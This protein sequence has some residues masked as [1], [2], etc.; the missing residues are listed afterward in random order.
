MA[1]L[2]V[3]AAQFSQ[4]F[5]IPPGNVTPIW[6]PSGIIIA[7]IIIRGNHVW[8]GIFLGAFFG[9]VWAYFDFQQFSNVSASLFAGSLNGLGNAG[10]GLLTIYLLKRF[11]R[12][13]DI[14]RRGKNVILFVFIGAVLPSF[15]SAL[16]G[17]SSLAISKILPWNNFIT[18]F[19]TWF[20]G[21]TAGIILVTPLIL[22]AKN[23]LSWKWL[24]KVKRIELVI[25]FTATILM[26]AV[27]IILSEA[28]THFSIPIISIL[29]LV[30]WGAYRLPIHINHFL[31]L[32]LSSGIFGLTLSGGGPFAHTEL[33][34]AL[35]EMQYFLLAFITAIL[36]IEAN[37]IDRLD[38]KAELETSEK[39]NRV[40]I[41]EFPIGLALCDMEGILVDINQPFADILGRSI[42]ESKSLTYWE[43]TPESYAKEEEVQ[44]NSLS[45]LGHYGPYEKDYIH[46]DSHLV[47]VRLQGK[48]INLN[49]VDYIWSSVENITAEKEFK[50]SLNAAREEAERASMAKSEFLS[51]MSHELRTPLNAIIGFC[52]ILENSKEQLDEKLQVAVAEIERGGDHLL[53]LVNEVLDLSQI[54]SGTLAMNYENIVFQEV[55]EECVQFVKPLLEL[56]KLKLIAPNDCTHVIHTDPL[57]LKQIIINFLSNAIKYN[58]ENGEIKLHCQPMSDMLRITVQ[59][60]G[61]GMDESQLDKLFQS[62]ER[63]GAEHMGIEGAGVG[64]A[65][66]KRMAELMK[67]EI[68]VSSELGKG[69]S[70]WIEVKQT[71]MP[72]KEPQTEAIP[73]EMA[74]NGK[75]KRIL[76]VDDNVTNLVLLE[77][78]FEK[79][80]NHFEFVTTVSALKALEIA[81]ENFDLI[82]LD[83]K[84]PEMD[85]YEVLRRLREEEKTKKIKVFAVSAN[86]MEED[87]N[88]ALNSGFEGY[89]TKPFRFKSM[90]EKLYKSLV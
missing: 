4:L 10:G 60:T 71:S 62:F 89:I 81:E 42:E 44:L 84:M 49:G 66:S 65:L 53:H 23:W 86:A 75:R 31:L 18:V 41:D 34:S 29:S 50:E 21:D 64:L 38:T 54:E 39:Y 19:S 76:Y 11:M 77:R 5:A 6:L 26:V 85:G 24:E 47:P 59:D 27:L 37:E 36:T 56:K 46:K 73:V 51:T 13:E 43:I 7:A 88:E 1:L 45:T 16:L 87:I 12:V 80:S 90:L 8:P 63:V 20:I 35:M 74:F 79:Y 69:S 48:I 78:L 67:C 72:R 28:T 70:F 14:F 9:N 25:F 82:L 57:R 68:G 83:I 33:N 58:K 40:L 15:I 55:I 52:Q 17:T 22:T 30:L 2:F 32:L 61:I 3:V